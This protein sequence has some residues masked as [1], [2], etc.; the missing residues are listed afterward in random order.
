MADTDTPDVDLKLP[1]GTVFKGNLQDAVS[2]LPN[3]MQP[4]LQRIGA[5]MA[6]RNPAPPSNA[7]NMAEQHATDLRSSADKIRAAQDKTQLAY[8]PEIMGARDQYGADLKKG[9]QPIPQPQVPKLKPEEITPVFGALMAFAALAGMGAR[10]HAVGALNA[11]NGVMEGSHTGNKELYDKS[12]KEFEEKSKLAVEAQNEAHKRYE[13]ILNNDKWNIEQKQEEM[14]IQLL[15]DGNYD[16]ADKLAEHGYQDFVNKSFLA[17]TAATKAA[18]KAKEF[19][20]G[21]SSDMSDPART[22]FWAQKYLKDKTLPP[23]SWGKSG[24]QDRELFRKAV[25]NEATEQGKSG[26]EVAAIQSDFKA[27]AASL[28][29]I[30]KRAGGI[31][32]GSEKIKRDIATMNS[33]LDKVAATGGAKVLNA[34]INKIRE[35]LSDADRGVLD[36]VTQQVGTEYERN[37][38]GGMNSVAQLHAGALEDGKSL[39]N[40]DMTIPEI[41]AKLPIMIQEINNFKSAADVVEGNLKDDMGDSSSS[42]EKPMSLDDY[43]KSKGH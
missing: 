27:K 18:E 35:M 7:L 41:R 42:Q 29:A 16:A 40:Q 10:N 9:E 21:A 3:S 36:L 20:M 11:M 17:E 28:A 12:I 26:S 30:E 24:Q 43:L 5:D 32:L 25:E 2:S 1:D 31:N 8:A 34:P 39:L 15:R 33:V 38:T 4:D 23:F 6:Q 19:S 14:R 13:S 22:K 37:L